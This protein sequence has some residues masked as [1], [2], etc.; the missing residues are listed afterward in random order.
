M[1]FCIWDGGRLPTEAEWEYVAVG[2]ADNRLYTWG[3]QAPDPTLANF[4][5]GANTQFLG[6]GSTSSGDGRW[7]H[8]DLAGGMWEWTYDWYD[9]DWYAKSNPCDDCAKT[10]SGSFRVLRGGSWNLDASYLRAAYRYKYNPAYHYNTFGFRCA[11]A[12]P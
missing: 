1:A 12:A 11:R 5:A 9:S 6:V 3:S 7:G 4:S 8:S 2:G 10:T